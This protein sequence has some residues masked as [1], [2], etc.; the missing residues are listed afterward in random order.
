MKMKRSRGELPARHGNCPITITSNKHDPARLRKPEQIPRLVP[1]VDGRV[2]VGRRDA[3]VG[4]T[5]G[6][7]NLGQCAAA[8]QGVANKGVAAVVDRE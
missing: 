6:V 4:V 2:Q 7:A 8:S 5:R 1:V 3:D